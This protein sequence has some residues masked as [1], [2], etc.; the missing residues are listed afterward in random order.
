[1][2]FMIESIRAQLEGIL[3]AFARLMKERTL[4]KIPA[5]DKVK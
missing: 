4:I 3:R 1:M 2:D 5:A